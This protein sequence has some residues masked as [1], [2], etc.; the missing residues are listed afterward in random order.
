M[1]IKTSQEFR[2]FYKICCMY[3]CLIKR[4]EKFR[5]NQKKT[6]WQKR[7]FKKFKWYTFFSPIDFGLIFVNQKRFF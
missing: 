3:W 1:Y 7:L 4:K 5:Q 6:F 2:L